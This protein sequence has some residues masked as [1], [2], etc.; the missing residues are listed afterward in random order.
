[1]SI[2]LVHV[3]EALTYKALYVWHI[4]SIIQIHVSYINLIDTR[5]RFKLDS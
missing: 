5:T 2:K 1:M 3:H 4:E